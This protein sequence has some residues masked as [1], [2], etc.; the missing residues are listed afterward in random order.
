MYQHLSLPNLWSI[1]PPGWTSRQINPRRMV[2]IIRTRKETRE[3]TDGP[4]ASASRAGRDPERK[5]A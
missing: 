2:R 3:G 1:I 4:P 5:P